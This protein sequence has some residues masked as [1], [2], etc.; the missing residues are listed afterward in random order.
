MAIRNR[1]KVGDYLMQDDESGFVHY[2]SEMMEIWDGTFRHRNNF[3]TRQPQ[4]FVRAK[5]DPRALVD[6]RI[7]IPSSAAANVESAFVGETGVP[8]PTG[9][10]SHL[11]GGNGIEFMKIET[12]TEP[13]IV[14]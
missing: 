9:P 10:A 2:A 3:E 12:A 7:E 13:F 5:N 14:A 8:T 1:H 6:V 11:F 4:E